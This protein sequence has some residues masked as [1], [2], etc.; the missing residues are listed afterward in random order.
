[1]RPILTVLTLLIALY[2]PVSTVSAKQPEEEASVL[3][4]VNLWKKRLYLQTSTGEVLASF[5]IAPG[6]VDTPSPIGV[7]SVIQKAKNWGGGFGSRW[8][9]INV[10]WGTYGIHGTNRPEQIGRYVSHG[11]FRMRNQDIE[12]IYPH[13]RIGTPVIIDGPIMGHERLTYRILVPGSRGSLVKLVQNRLKA[14]GYYGGKVHGRFDKQ[15]EQ[16]VFRFQK[17]E[18]LPVTGQIRFED[19]VHLGIVE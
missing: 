2:A 18:G 12:K 7:Y 17:G 15:T 13:V 4:Y 3:L 10:E 16:A 11:C 8:L 19:L 5:P 14:A 6:A 1:M 9:G